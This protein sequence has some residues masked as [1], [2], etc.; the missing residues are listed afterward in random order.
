[1]DAK[2]KGIW[3]HM[4]GLGL[5][6]LAHANRHTAYLDFL[7]GKWNELAVL[8][9]AHAAELLV[10]AR[11]AQEH[12]LLIFEEL[13]RSSKLN[14]E[15]LDAASLF[16]QG[17]TIQWSDLPERLWAATG[18]KLPDEAVFRE[19]GRLRNGIQHFGPPQGLDTQKQTLSFVFRVIDPFINQHWG[20][21]AIDYDEDEEP[22]VY[23]MQAL[24][25]QE[26]PFLVSRPAAECFADWSVDWD[27][28]SPT[29]R[30][31]IEDRVATALETTP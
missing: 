12:P 8:Q 13:P 5:A 15:L 19:F 27:N 6:A 7:N 3:E 1:M 23:F 26:V 20:L 24:V 11:I 10:K 28:V 16:A 17:R 21:F 25:A 22:Y 14:G 30:M 31:M 29:Y 4:R 9:A 2:L 18:C